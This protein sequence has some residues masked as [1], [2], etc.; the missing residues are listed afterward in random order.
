MHARDLFQIRM[1]NALPRMATSGYRC[2]CESSDISSP[3]LSTTTDTDTNLTPQHRENTDEEKRRMRNARKKRLRRQKRHDKSIKCLKSRLVTAQEKAQ[4]NETRIIVLKR[5]TR[6]FWERWRWELEKRKEAMTMAGLTARQFH[7]QRTTVVHLQEIDSSMLMDPQFSGE[8]QECYLGRGSFGAVKLQLY[9]GFH[10]AVKEFLPRAL[11]DDVKKEAEILALLCHPFLPYLFGICTSARPLRIVMQYHGFLDSSTTTLPLAHT[12]S[13]ELFKPSFNMQ[14]TDWL[15]VCAQLLDAVNYLHT[16]ADLLHND[17]KGD[18]VIFGKSN[19]LS[20]S[21][22]MTSTAGSTQF[23]V[24]L[25]D[26]GKATKSM[27]GKLYHLT[28]HEKE[29]YRIRYMHI[30]PEVIEGECRQTTY[31]DMYAV[32]SLLYRITE[33]RPIKGSASIAKML[34]NI[35]E[36][37]CGIQYHR[38]WTAHKALVTIQDTLKLE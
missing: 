11:K 8:Q 9:R 13:N 25:I 7:S 28:E 5:M 27:Q 1:R 3:E 6:T 26:F 15:I 38:R 10:V 29:S 19:N 12:L 22:A 33:S 36:K 4:G 31:S 32:G 30:A 16:S 34:L 14:T 17:I 35:A 24:V 2:G 20:T 37:C 18:N 21:S 23:Q